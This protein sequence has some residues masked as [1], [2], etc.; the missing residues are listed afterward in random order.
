MKTLL[1][2]IAAVL[3]MPTG[4]AWAVCDQRNINN[5]LEVGTPPH[6]SQWQSQTATA[7]ATGGS[8]TVDNGGAGLP[9]IAIAPTIVAPGLAAGAFVCL[10][11][12]SGGVSVGVVGVGAGFT[13]GTTVEDAR[14]NAR[15][16]AA[17][18][19]GL[20]DADVARLR[21]CQMADIAAAYALAGRPCAKAAFRPMSM[22][23]CLDGFPA[24]ATAEGG[25]TCAK[26]RTY[27]R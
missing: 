21:L 15:A 6:T 2:L 10:G 23:L 26:S 16:D 22:P 5:C 4:P 14:C 25:Y 11:S 12:K 13:L 8:A 18:L 24:G 17:T 20:G 27:Q 9:G 7:T 19:V 3:L 1:G